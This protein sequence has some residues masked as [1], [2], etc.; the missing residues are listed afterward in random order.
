MFTHRRFFSAHR[1]FQNTF[2]IDGVTSSSVVAVSLT[3]VDS[4]HTPIAGNATLHLYNVV[5]MTGQV[6][7]RAEIDFDDDRP[8]RFDFICE[9]ENTMDE[10]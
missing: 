9:N 1:L 5:P 4:N 10:F 3:E 7:V 8:I 6:L 2:D